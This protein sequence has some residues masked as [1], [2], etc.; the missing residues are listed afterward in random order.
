L[1]AERGAPARIATSGDVPALVRLINRAYRVEDFFI[2]GDRTHEE[3]VRARMARPEGMFLVVDGPDGRLDAAV[4][5][6]LR[7]DRGYFGMLSVDPD[8]QGQGLGRALVQAAE[9]HCRAAGCH[10][11]DIEVV[12]LRHELTAFYAALGFTTSG[13]A[14]FPDPR[15]LRQP[16]HLVTMSK[17]IGT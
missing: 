9:Q 8:R 7:G 16:A 14:P 17:R 3:D 2:D 11:L 1:G 13:T 10:L 5:V 12:N 4:N 6:E 15:K